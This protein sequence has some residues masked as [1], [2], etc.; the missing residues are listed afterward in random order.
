LL[1]MGMALLQQFAGGG[2]T[3]AAGDDRTAAPAERP[4]VVRDERSGETY[5]KVPMPQPEVLEQALR[6]V[7]TLLESLRRRE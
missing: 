6:A 4:A 1:Q 2:R 3:G 5:L 7:G